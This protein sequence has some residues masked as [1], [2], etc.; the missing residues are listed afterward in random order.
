VHHVHHR[1]DTERYQPV[2]PDPEKRKPM[3]VH[4]P[5]Q[6]GV[7]GTEFIEQAL[8]ELRVK[9]MEFEYVRVH[10]LTHAKAMAVYRKA[11]IVVDQLLLGSHGVFACEA[12]ALGKPVICYI[13]DELVDTYPEGFPV[14]NANPDTIINV[15]EEVVASPERRAQIG[16]AGREYVERVHDI[17][18]V[19]ERLE[20][21]YRQ[22]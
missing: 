12:M 1:I 20:K 21:I 18:Q 4:A 3:V 10:G 14:I 16:R 7:K 5:S 11:D 19:A 6:P 13:L 2:Y 9:G 22:L 15:L 17:R 8:D